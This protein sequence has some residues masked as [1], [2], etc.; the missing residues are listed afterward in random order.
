M[1]DLIASLRTVS[2]HNLEVRSLDNNANYFT[3]Q[4]GTFY[5][6]IS[7]T[8]FSVSW[9]HALTIIPEY[10]KIVLLI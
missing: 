9:N 1:P 6:P 4:Q 3:V 5:G 2:N 8:Q 7:D 10:Q